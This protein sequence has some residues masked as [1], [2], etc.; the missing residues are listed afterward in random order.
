MSFT[1]VTSNISYVPIVPSLNTSMPGILF[2]KY[3]TVGPM[4]VMYEYT[5]CVLYSV[6][7]NISFNVSIFLCLYTSKSLYF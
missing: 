4:Y 3:P 1:A 5:V 6:C 7:L 2:L